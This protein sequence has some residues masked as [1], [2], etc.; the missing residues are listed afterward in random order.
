FWL[1]RGVDGF[2]LD[3]GDYL[4]HDAQLRANPERAPADGQIPVKPFR[5]QHHAHDMMQPEIVPALERIRAFMNQYP[6]SVTLG[7]ISREPPSAERCGLYP[8]GGGRRL[9]MAYTLGLPKHEFS[10]RFVRDA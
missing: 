8:G 4:N 6:G 5:L 9:H 2:R 1:D 7:E 10:S 3:A